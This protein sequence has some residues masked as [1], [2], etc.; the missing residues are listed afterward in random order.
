MGKEKWARVLRCIDK[1][2]VHVAGYQVY[3]DF[4]LLMNLRVGEGFTIS[5]GRFGL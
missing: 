5:H 1:V 2:S 4:D 3:H